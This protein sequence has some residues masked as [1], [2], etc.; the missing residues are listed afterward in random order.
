MS[1]LFTFFKTFH[2]W[3]TVG[4]INTWI[5]DL[6]CVSLGVKRQKCTDYRFAEPGDSSSFCH[7][8]TWRS[9]LQWVHWTQSCT[10]PWLLALEFK[11]FLSAFSSSNHSMEWI[12]TSLSGAEH[13]CGTEHT[14]AMVAFHNGWNHHP[15]FCL[16]C[17]RKCVSSRW[18]PRLSLPWPFFHP[19]SLLWRHLTPTTLL[20]VKAKAEKDRTGWWLKIAN[21]VES[22]KSICWKSGNQI[23][24]VPGKKKTTQKS[25]WV[26]YTVQRKGVPECQHLARP[27]VA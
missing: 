16:G 15:P 20:L 12:Q 10:N 21:P 9:L 22:D 3:R 1:P 8:L 4:I 14:E 19:L 13:L 2:L 25:W 24:W 27:R 7:P 6:C 17:P 26:V 11:E 23:S 5:L 18:Q